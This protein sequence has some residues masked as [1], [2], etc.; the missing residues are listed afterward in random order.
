VAVTGGLIGCDQIHLVVYYLPNK[1]IESANIHGFDHLTDD[2]TLSANC[3]DNRNLARR[4]PPYVR[5]L[6][7]VFVL[8]PSADEG[9]VYFHDAHQLTKIGIEHTSA[10]PMAHIESRAVRSATDHAMNLQS[11]DP[12]LRR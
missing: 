12:F 7:G 5:A 1:A 8:F 11:A 10:K 9:L 6:V 4:T 3:S 2:V